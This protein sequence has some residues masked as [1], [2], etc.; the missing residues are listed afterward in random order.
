MR[1]ATSRAT[2]SMTFL[3]RKA[4]C[5]AHRALGPVAV[6]APKLRQTADIGRGVVHDLARQRRFGGLLLVRF[7]RFV[8]AA[9]LV[10]PGFYRNRRGGHFGPADVHRG[11]CAEIGAGRHRCDMACVQDV[12]AGARRAGAARG[13][14]R[15][16]WN[17]RSEDRLDD[18]AH[19]KVESTGCVHLQHHEVDALACRAV[20][21][22]DDEIGGG[23]SDRAMDR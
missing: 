11:C 2:T 17:R 21:A 3:R 14:E 8:A 10:A 13:D 5:F 19:R 12:R 22:A 18:V 9:V 20:D 4:H 16:H 1:S 7:G 15:H 6:A 23:R